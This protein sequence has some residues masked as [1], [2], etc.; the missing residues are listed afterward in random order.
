MCC[1]PSIQC[2]DELLQDAQRNLVR[3]Q[4]LFRLAKMNMLNGQEERARERG[5]HERW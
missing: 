2:T 4:R 3:A 5:K 1:C